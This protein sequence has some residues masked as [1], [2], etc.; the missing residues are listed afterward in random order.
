M[1]LASSQHLHEGSDRSFLAILTDPIV[2]LFRSIPIEILDQ[3]EEL[4][5]SQKDFFDDDEIEGDLEEE[6]DEFEDILQ[7]AILAT[8]PPTPDPDQD[9]P[10]IKDLI[11]KLLDKIEQLNPEP[12]KISVKH[13]TPEDNSHVV[14]SEVSTSCTFIRSQSHA[15]V[16]AILPHTSYVCTLA[17]VS[18]T[19]PAPAPAPKK[20][21][22]RK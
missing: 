15:R 21:V 8:P 3:N 13:L 4:S 17:P 10:D 20:V 5:P 7:D 12:I 2:S 14:R 22:K 18:A 11:G 6:E 19:F 9:A 16:K 1:V